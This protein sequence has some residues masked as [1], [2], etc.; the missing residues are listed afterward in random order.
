[1]IR[2][3]L[4]R[5]LM[6]AAALV[7]LALAWQAAISLFGI[8]AY[9]IPGPA[10]VWAAFVE[11]RV[12]I[13]E[14]A[15]L[16]LLSSG[17]GLAVS[18]TLA[19][20]LSV[21]FVLYKSVGQ[22]SM[23]LIVVLRSAPVAAIAPI[24]MLIAGRGMGTSVVVVVIVS[25][26]PI[27]VNLMRG[28]RGADPLAME[29]MHVCGATRWQ[30]VRY[31]QAPASLPFLFTGLRIAGANAILGALLAEWI[32]GSPGLGLLILETGDLREVET[33]WAAVIVTM[34]VALSVFAVTSSAE[35]A[36]LR[37]T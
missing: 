10:A 33:L 23:P 19:I 32:T 29:L 9:L 21:I 27:M 14:H 36:V 15:G 18:C 7:G 8:P 1:M 3:I 12:T 35:K 34:A 5:T 31:V 28:L 11:K 25:F 4:V 26:F 16:T 20:V 37:W 13:A 6:L 30:Q 2:L 22:A 24:I 17:L